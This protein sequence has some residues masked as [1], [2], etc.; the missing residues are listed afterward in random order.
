MQTWKSVFAFIIFSAFVVTHSQNTGRCLQEVIYEAAGKVVIYDL[1]LSIPWN[2]VYLIGP[3][4]KLWVVPT[5]PKLQEHTVFFPHY[6]QS[7]SNGSGVS[8][9]HCVFSPGA[10]ESEQ[11]LMD[12]IIDPLKNINLAYCALPDGLLSTLQGRSNVSVTVILQPQDAQHEAVVLSNLPICLPPPR[13]PAYA[14]LC[15][16]VR[17]EARYLKEWIEYSRM[18]GIEHFLLYDHAST[19]NMAEVLAPYIE[20]QIVTLHNW[21]FPGYPQREVHSHCM[22]RYGHLTSWLGLLD[23]DEFIV[24]ARAPSLV[25]LLQFFEHD[26]VIL[27]LSALQFGTSGHRRRPAGLVT[28]H[29]T[30][31][32]VSAWWPNSPQHKV[33]QRG[34]WCSRCARL[35]ARE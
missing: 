24:P 35:S 11:T 29:Y 26:P 32:N 23:V 25:S 17:N 4:Q 10:G 22:L 30:A 3:H 18:I 14:S 16:I 12:F 33:E 9:S 5:V 31:R 8:G 20:A 21:S 27:R 34:G 13:P 7:G 28:E 19:D 1:V 6:F 15:C 2:S